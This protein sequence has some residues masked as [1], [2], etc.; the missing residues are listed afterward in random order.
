MENLVQSLVDYAVASQTL[1]GEPESGDQYL[2]QGFRMGVLVAVVDGLG[3]GREA[4][5]A[6][7][8]AIETLKEHAEEPLVSLVS[9]CQEKLRHGRGVV[10]SLASFRSGDSIMNWMGIGNVSGVLVRANHG[11]GSEPKAL[12]MRAGV[13]GG[14][15]PP[16]QASRIQVSRGDTLIFATDGVSSGFYDQLQASDPPRK[17]AEHV[18]RTYVKG[19]D[20]AMVLVARLLGETP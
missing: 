19:A 3:H 12:L 5:Q 14:S 15:L 16:L 20:D 9:C 4:A 11:S 1:A 10:M 17:I 13:V 2:V 6:A 8:I 18:L 7:A